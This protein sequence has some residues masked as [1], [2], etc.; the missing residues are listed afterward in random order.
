MLIAFPVYVKWH[1]RNFDE[2][3]IY[4][5]LNISSP[6]SNYFDE[7]VSIKINHKGYQKLNLSH[8]YAG[9]YI[10][11]VVTDKEASF[12]GDMK[13][14]NMVLEFSSKDYLEYVEKDK[15]YWLSSYSVPSEIPFNSQCILKFDT[16]KAV[17]FKIIKLSHS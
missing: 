8:S 4:I 6:P 11:K 15:E 5:V 3:F 16:S 9:K 10:V 17:T 14:S 13:C 2:G 1:L 12:F 7:I